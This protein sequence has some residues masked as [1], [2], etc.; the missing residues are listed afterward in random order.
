MHAA[1]VAPGQVVGGVRPRGAHSA[2]LRCITT[3]QMSWTVSQS[4]TSSPR[5]SPEGRLRAWDPPTSC[6]PPPTSCAHATVSTSH[7][8][9]GKCYLRA[10]ALYTVSSALSMRPKTGG[11]FEAAAKSMMRF[12]TQHVLLSLTATVRHT[13]SN[14]TRRTLKLTETSHSQRKVPV[15]ATERQLDT[16]CG[17]MSLC[18]A[19]RTLKMYPFMSLSVRR[20]TSG[21]PSVLPVSR[22]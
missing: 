10:A 16:A 3:W 17:N 11:F 20:M 9:W 21:V 5:P 19:A 15:A 18:C 7:R 4:Q 1:D 13:D 6:V 2:A 12:L 8:V 14:S 22:M